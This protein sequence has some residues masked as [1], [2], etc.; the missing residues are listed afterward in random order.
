MR[1]LVV[2]G[3]T[4]DIVNARPKRSRGTS[5]RSGFLTSAAARG[6]SLFGET[7]SDP[8][9]IC[10]NE[11]L[12]GPQW[13][14]VATHCR[15]VRALSRGRVCAITGSSAGNA[16]FALGRVNP[17][18]ARRS[19]I[20]AGILSS[21]PTLPSG[22][23]FPSSTNDVAFRKLSEGKCREIPPIC[24]WQLRMPSASIRPSGRLP[25]SPFLECR[26][27]SLSQPSAQIWDI[28]LVSM[29]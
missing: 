22:R 8:R 11:R 24:E 27:F 25:R 1:T 14:S 15:T 18:K 21:L 10:T 16:P 13:S 2:D 9:A 4:A 20:I 5:L 19:S 17:L 12:A 26:L 23:P 3:V 7:D 6:A 29:L 28:R